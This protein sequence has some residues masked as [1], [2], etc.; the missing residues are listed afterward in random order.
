MTKRTY[1][2]YGLVPY[3]LSP[4]QQGI[5]FGHA[6]VEYSLQM[7]DRNEDSPIKIAYNRWAKHDKTFII[8][9]GGT[10]NNRKFD[11]EYVGTLNAHLAA[12][13]N[14][15][16]KSGHPIAEFREPDLGDQLTAFVFL[17]DD[18]VFDKVNYPD[19]DGVNTAE[20]YYDWKMKFGADSNI[21]DSIIFMRDH[22]SGLKLA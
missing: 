12:I 1:R 14:S 11:G 15:Y 5:Q 7:A 3:N 16:G 18:R 10:T 8:L 9:N 6:V 21:V 4:I 20:A 22:L 17:V 2:M 19:F 13:H